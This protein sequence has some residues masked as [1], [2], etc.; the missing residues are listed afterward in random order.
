MS[1]TEKT[2]DERIKDIEHSIDLS[3]DN[4][5]NKQIFD[6]WMGQVDV[7]RE[8][9]D[10]ILDNEDWGRN[11]I[12]TFLMGKAAARLEAATE[13]NDKIHEVETKISEVKNGK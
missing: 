1:K 11:E 8:S 6:K 10:R 5:S 2:T 12:I 3:I 13:L 4:Q 7:I 9:I